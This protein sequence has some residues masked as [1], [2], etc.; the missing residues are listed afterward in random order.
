[1]S[2][3]TNLYRDRRIG[4]LATSLEAYLLNLWP[5]CHQRGNRPRGVNGCAPVREL[6]KKLQTFC[7]DNMNVLNSYL[8]RQFGFFAAISYLTLAYCTP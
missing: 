8:M 2:T 4:K 1:M 3:Y 6:V 7:S 5:A